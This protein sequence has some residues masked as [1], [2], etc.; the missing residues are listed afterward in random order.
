MLLC[1][2]GKGLE[3]QISDLMAQFLRR[4]YVTKSERKFKKPKPGKQ[5]LVKYPKTLEVHSVRLCMGFV[6]GTCV[7]ITVTFHI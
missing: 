7:S 3:D 4:K 6:W 2:A 1:T 5:R